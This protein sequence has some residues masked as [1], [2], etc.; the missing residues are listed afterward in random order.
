MTYTNRGADALLKAMGAAMLAAGPV[1]LWR[2]RSGRNEIRNELT[3]QKI[4]FPEQGLPAHLAAFAGRP[5]ET[6]PEA[7]AFADMIKGNLAIAT[8]GRTY[9]E[10]SAELNAA[11]DD[12][13][14]AKLRQTAFMGE[15]L[16]A[17]LMS[18]YQAWQITSLVTGLGALLT[19]VGAALV[20]SAREGSRAGVTAALPAVRNSLHSR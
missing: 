14:L 19:G 15:T 11:R 16:R 18:A 17:S 7:R 4:A 12:E 20:V 6:G 13:K 8:N 9:S 1:M 2:S 10:I 5:V 3:A